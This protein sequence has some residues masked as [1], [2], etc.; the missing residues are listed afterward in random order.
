MEIKFFVFCK[1]LCSKTLKLWLQDI[2]SQSFSEGIIYNI[3]N[4]N[5]N[6]TAAKTKQRS[7]KQRNKPKTWIVIDNLFLH[8]NWENRLVI[9]KKIK[10]Q[11]V[12][13]IM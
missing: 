5:S 9:I 13:Q 3:D 8:S 1:L 11:V 10:L 4:K 6:K 12:M 7:L 2:Y